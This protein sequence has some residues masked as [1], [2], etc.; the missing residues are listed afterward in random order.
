M[1][2]LRMGRIQVARRLICKNDIGLV[3]QSPGHRHP[4]LLPTR[5]RTGLVVYPVPNAKHSQQIERP[6]L[7]FPLSPTRDPPRDTDI[8]QCA[9][10]RQQVMEL[11]YKTDMTVAERRQRTAL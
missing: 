2:F 1:Q 10:L 4:L 9:E 8:L 11:E 7:H 5:Q 3:D 6:L